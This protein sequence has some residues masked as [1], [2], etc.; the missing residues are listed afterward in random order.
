M[1]LVR[2]MR[3]TVSELGLSDFASK[4]RSREIRCNLV[5]TFQIP[6]STYHLK[7]MY[8]KST[9]VWLVEEL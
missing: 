4:H 8:N 2:H 7:R 5:R 9:N 1:Y 3:G 6:C